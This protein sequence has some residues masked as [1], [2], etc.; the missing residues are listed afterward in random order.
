M[1]QGMM[2]DYLRKLCEEGLNWRYGTTDVSAEVRTRLD[3]ELKI[4][5]MKNFCSYFLIVWDFCN[6]ARENG[7]PSAR[8]AQASARW[9]AICWAYVMSIRFNMACSSSG[10]WTRAVMRCPISTS[11]SA[12]TAG[13]K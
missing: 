11:T 10:S 4:I 6:F 1:P 12:R 3:Y 2:S 13:R 8:E 5:C 7:I 9:W